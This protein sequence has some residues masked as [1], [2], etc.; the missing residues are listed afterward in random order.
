VQRCNTSITRPI[1]RLWKQL[2]HFRH[3]IAKNDPCRPTSAGLKIDEVAPV[4][5]VPQP[6][7]SDQPDIFL[8]RY[9]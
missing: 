8:T 6:A 4:G 1:A 9:L 2:H 7:T 3:R 5:G